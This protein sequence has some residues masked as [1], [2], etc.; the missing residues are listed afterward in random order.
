MIPSTPTGK[1]KA[2]QGRNGRRDVT[3]VFLRL[4][5]C[6]YS[7]SGEG[8][9]GW[10]ETEGRMEGRSEQTRT[11]RPDSGSSPPQQQK[12]GTI[13]R[14]PPRLFQPNRGAVHIFHAP[15]LLGTTSHSRK[16]YTQIQLRTH[17]LDHRKATEHFLT[18]EPSGTR[19]KTGTSIAPS[20]QA[21][22]SSNTQGLLLLTSG[23]I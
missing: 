2:L 9:G 14:R 17:M 20:L 12:R 7:W 13:S 3:P 1:Q 8:G 6:W 19:T 11:V 23:G 15:L 22:E 16:P 5:S 18:A 10:G 21:Y 4:L